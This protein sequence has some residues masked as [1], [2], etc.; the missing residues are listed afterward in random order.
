MK[1]LSRILPSTLFVSALMLI[2]SAAGAEIAQP[3]ALAVDEL[4]IG[5]CGGVYFLA[6]PGEL[7][8]EIVKR[9][10]NRRD[11][12]TE[13]RAILAGPDRRVLQEATIPDDG[14]PR[15]SGMGPAQ[16][17]RL[18]AHVKRKGVYVLNI[19]LSQDR[20]GEHAV[21]GFRSNC[22]KYLIETARGH[23]DARHEEPI[24]LASPEHPGNVCFLPRR[25]A[26]DIEV[27]DLPKGA[28]APQVFD[29]KGALVTALRLDEGGQAAHAFA[30][31]KQREATPWRLHFASA[32][33]T[34][35]MDGV[36]RWEESD[37]QPNLACWTPDLASWFPLLENRWL[38]TPYSR[39]IF[40]RPGE[41]KEIAL[42]VR[43]DATRERTIQLAL[44]FPG[45]DWP[46]RL[47]AERVKL[48]GKKATTITVTCAAP[49]T[50]ETRVC[51]IRATPL[52]DSGFTTFSTLTVKS[53]EAP[54][55]KPLTMPLV[56][57]PYQHENEQF[58]HLPDFPTENQVYFDVQ[59]QPFI[60]TSGGVATVRDGKRIALPAGNNSSAV[61][62]KVAFDRDNNLY[63]LAT[64]GGAATL[65][66]S[67]DGGQTF[68]AC[69]I[70]GR[71]GTFDMEEFTGHNLPAGP[72]PILR[73]T[74]TAKD[75][76][77]FWR[78]LHDLELF[79]P[80]KEGGRLVMGE[81]I[82]VSKKCI[83][84]AA[85]S[86]IPA[87]VVSRGSKVHVVWGEATDPK[88]PGPGVPAFVATHD[89]E[90][91]RLGKPALI[92]YGAPPNDIHNSPSIAMD[93]R[94]FLH[95]LAGTHGRPFPYAQ[96]LKPNDAGGGWTDAAPMVENLNQTYIGMVCGPD[97]TLHAT[98]RLWQTG[99]DPFPASHYATLAYQRKRPGQPWEPPRILIVPPF[100]EY[101]VFYHRL[102]IDRKGRLFL[103]YDYW[104]TF[105]F[106][107]ND[108]FGR[109]R[110][111]LMSPDGGDTWQLAQSNN[112]Q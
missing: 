17:C 43:N 94:G 57:K 105:W 11:T 2:S 73:Y 99:V 106:Y 60:R 101:S 30:A 29:A 72:P 75:P 98:F 6:E 81:P 47:S 37:L 36:T 27:S 63:V 69:A 65:L 48:G 40:G 91:G 41:R 44:E 24:V 13:L 88:A 70:P 23:R 14:R 15:G 61:C 103:S 111:L 84:L 95:A 20:Y 50:G 80:K 82:L 104:S 55:T 22:P 85:H 56:L 58:G 1:T 32:Q 68:A 59:N 9:D 53:S 7:M 31:S 38:L 100:S 26:F 52:D 5:G 79:L 16:R 51:H 86:G 89:R 12:R 25:G 28:V 62:S 108:H 93:S 74:R 18:S 66:C 64:V 102:T 83:G 67:S 33:A 96:S 77:V 4:L 45:S 42:Q 87:S 107:R 35:N 110:T 78:A 54:A 10:R 49:P 34:V 76:K 112:L 3:V 19:T 21:W 46:A 109:R 90:T 92:G 39:T 97:D 8:V 71:A